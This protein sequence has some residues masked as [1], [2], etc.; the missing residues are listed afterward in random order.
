MTDSDLGR[1]HWQARLA[2]DLAAAP[3]ADVAS[4]HAVAERVADI[5]RPAGALARLDEVA[6]WLAGWQRT[7]TPAV[8]RPAAIIFAGDHGVASLSAYPAEVTGAMVEAFEKN[9]ASISA[10]AAAVGAT[11]DVVDVG[12][13]APTGDIR[14]E[15]AMDQDRLQRSFD[16]GRA[17]VA[18]L[19]DDYGERDGVD[20][21]IVG[22]MGIGN[23]TAAAAVICALLGC[24]ADMIVGRGTGVDDEGLA[25]KI[26][27][28]SAAVA[29]FHEQLPEVPGTGSGG[30]SLRTHVGPT[31]NDATTAL[32]ALRQL[33]G[34]ELAA[35]AGALVEARCRSLPVLLDGFVVGASAMVVQHLHPEASRHLWAGHR[36]GEHGHAAVL[37][38]LELRPLLDLDLRLGEASGAMAA[39]PL[40]RMACALVT[41]VPTFTE[42]FGSASVEQSG[43]QGS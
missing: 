25:R 3:P 14:I 13:G 7:A 43:Q 38:H 39:V 30:R 9:R 27:A 20:L 29:R 23:T 12:V 28:V 41:E 2:A 22:E 1:S 42:W 8:E 32:E 10:M 6:V 18:S 19:S 4:R 26:G 11:V 5:L 36:S 37:D 21:L 35:M 40:V 31:T 33:G 16:R 17:A 15:P 34:T 24:P